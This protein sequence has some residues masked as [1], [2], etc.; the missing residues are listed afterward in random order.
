MDTHKLEQFVEIFEYFHGYACSV[1]SGD[2]DLNTWESKDKFIVE[3]EILKNNIED[4]KK[5]I[6]HAKGD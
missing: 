5:I 2:L 4:F 1:M 6:R 3:S